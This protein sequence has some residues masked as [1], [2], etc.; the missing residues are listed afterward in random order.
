MED[1][2]HLFFHLIVRHVDTQKECVHV[3]QSGWDGI[4]Q[5]VHVYL[6]NDYSLCKPTYI[7]KTNHRNIVLSCRN[8]F[9]CCFTLIV[10][11]QILFLKN[12]CSYD[13]GKDLKIDNSLCI[14]HSETDNLLFIFKP[15]NGK[16]NV[17]IHY[18]YM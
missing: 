2:V 13:I 3:K 18:C 11:H 17:R 15:L 12:F 7:S 4:A 8:I 14:Q 1:I 10:N 9:Q 6:F 5:K 16:Q